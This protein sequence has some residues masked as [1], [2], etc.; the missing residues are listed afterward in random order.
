M[1]LAKEISVESVSLAKTKAYCGYS[2][3]F[4]VPGAEEQDT[5]LFEKAQQQE[6]RQNR[7]RISPEQHAHE[8][9]VFRH[10]SQSY[11]EM[12]QLVTVIELYSQWAE[13]EENMI[14]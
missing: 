6:K 7:L 10:V 4:T 14:A 2:F 12:Q 9:E 13:E 8:V 11:Y 5:D 1:K 3:D